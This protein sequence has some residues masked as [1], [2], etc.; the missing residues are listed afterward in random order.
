MMIINI[1]E[2]YNDSSTISREV[3]EKLTASSGLLSQAI[4]D[5]K[6]LAYGLRLPGLNEMGLV[7]ALQIY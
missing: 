3:Q 5:I 1:D 2:I 4:K 6:K 7:K